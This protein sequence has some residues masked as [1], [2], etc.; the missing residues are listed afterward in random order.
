MLSQ[1]ELASI[2]KLAL[3]LRKIGLLYEHAHSRH[4]RTGQPSPSTPSGMGH[5]DLAYCYQQVPDIF[6]RADFSLENASHFQQTLALFGGAGTQGTSGGGTADMTPD[7]LSAYLDLVEI[8]LLRQIWCQSPAFFRALDDVR[9]LQATVSSTTIQLQAFRKH[10]Q[11][12]DT[13]IAENALSIPRLSRRQ[14][15][16]QSVHATCQCLKQL[17]AGKQTLFL[18]LEMEDYITAQMVIK[19]LLQVYKQQAGV[20]AL[21]SFGDD[22]V[23]WEEMIHVILIKQFVSL[24]LQSPDIRPFLSILIASHQLP[25]ALESYGGRLGDSIKVIIRT[26]VNEYSTTDAEPEASPADMPFQQRIKDMPVDSFLAC[27]VLCYDQLIV[28]VNTAYALHAVLTADPPAGDAGDPSDAGDAGTGY[29]SEEGPVSVEIRLQSSAILKAA[30]DLI[31]KSIAQILNVRKDGKLSDAQMKAL[32][33]DAMGFVNKMEAHTAQLFTLRQA[34]LAVYKHF[35]DTQHEGN[36]HLLVDVLDNE[37]WIPCDIHADKQMMI[38]RLLAGQLMLS[39]AA[40]TSAASTS[41]ATST[42]SAAVPKVKQTRPVLVEGVEYHVAY[43][44]IKLL[45][46]VLSYLDIITVTSS[47]NLLADVVNKIVEMVRLF[48][49]RCKQLVLGAQAIQSTKLKSITAKH[50]AITAMSLSF[51]ILLLPHLRAVI[52]MQNNKIVLVE[53]DRISSELIDH[54]HQLMNKFLSIVSDMMDNASSQLLPEGISE[55][56]EDVTK[57]TL[58]LHKVLNSILPRNAMEDVFLGIFQMINR[59]I[60][61]HFEDITPSTS[62]R[63]RILDEMSHFVITLSKLKYVDTTI[64]TGQLEEQFRKKYAR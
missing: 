62:N 19:E 7:R 50:L 2:D 1:H 26:C 64:L 40:P 4:F 21:R 61:M 38:N 25:R 55:Y 63:Q 43:S 15:N 22:L 8:A 57:N 28:T 31:Q 29:G 6:F 11:A 56:F 14:K 44:I 5:N 53:M 59:K 10:I 48:N 16:L 24:A 18:L 3:R 51:F 41:S 20:A 34:V 13:S 47:P 37:R 30:V 60:S 36:K 52:V 9:G 46:I 54:Q 42:S 35:L 23:E 45:D 32:Y 17:L 39:T 49:N 12:T 58:T 33:N 27:L